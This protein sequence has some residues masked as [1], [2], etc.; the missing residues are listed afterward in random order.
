MIC[1]SSISPKWRLVKFVSTKEY[2]R[3]S[4]IL[5]NLI[6]N[7]YSFKMCYLKSQIYRIICKNSMVESFTGHSGTVGARQDS[8]YL[9]LKFLWHFKSIFNLKRM[10]NGKDFKFTVCLRRRWNWIQLVLLFMVDK[11]K[12]WSVF[13]K[14]YIKCVLRKSSFNEGK[15]SNFRLFKWPKPL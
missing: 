8:F 5:L 4:A 15:F 10:R 9:G 1:L 3:F 12:N 14:K 11:A 2:K 13:L 6:V 7:F